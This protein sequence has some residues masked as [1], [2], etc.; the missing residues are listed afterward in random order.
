MKEIRNIKVRQ[1]I[2][3]K[4]AL[5]AGFIGGIISL[6]SNILISSYLLDSPWLF[7]RIIASVLMGEGVL[8]PP[9]DF[10]WPVFLTGLGIHLVLS[11]VFACVIAAVVHQWGILISFLGGALLGL[12]FYAINFYTLSL[13]FPWFYPFRNW[14]FLLL[15]VLYGALTGGVYEL[16]EVERYIEIDE[17]GK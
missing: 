4:A 6:F 17:G 12:A 9:A 11:L 13:L 5:I 14:I 15:Y 16:L 7:M 3:W 8:P 10:T 1:L 2:D